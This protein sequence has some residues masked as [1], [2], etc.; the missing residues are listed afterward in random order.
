MRIRRFPIGVVLLLASLAAPVCAHQAA[1]T[2]QGTITEHRLADL[3]E[4]FFRAATAHERFALAASVEEE[5]GG[6]FSTVAEV[7]RGVNLWSAPTADHGTFFLEGDATGEVVETAYRLPNDYEPGR[8]YPLLFCQPDDRASQAQTLT[9]AAGVLGDS[10]RGFVLVCPKYAVDGSFTRPLGDQEDLP[11]FIRAIRRRLHVDSDRVFL[12]GSDTGG[13]SAWIT[14][15]MHSDL[16]AGAVIRSG[17]PRVPYPNQTLP[18][19]LEN[20]RPLRILTAWKNDLDAAATARQR[21][22]E[23]YNR[24]IVGFAAPASLQI[25]GV[26][27]T[28]RDSPGA[29]TL[30]VAASRV[31]SGRRSWP[32]RKLSH[33]F[34]YPEQG[35]AGWLRQVKPREPV[36]R[37]DQLSILPAPITDRDD[38]VAEVVQEKL[39]YLA[40]RIEGRSVIVEVERCARVDLLLPYQLLDWSKP[41]SVRCNGRVRHEG[42]IRPSIKTMLETAYEEW[43]FQHL[44]AVRLSFAVRPRDTGS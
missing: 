21:L 32:E 8:R 24:A 10:V 2:P 6:D 26:D 5:A 3:V 4:A 20:L 41:I 9:R 31:L 28:D 33:W 44:V 34:R 37:A 25:I 36:W 23:T 17:Y 16:F 39:A 35:R 42:R 30:A 15:L 7:V 14:A 18:F 13:D 43:E 19:L 1:A 38:F 12:Y 11:G 27:P 40:G 29:E 22:V